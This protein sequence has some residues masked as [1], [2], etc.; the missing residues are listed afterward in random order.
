MAKLTGY[1]VA[2]V[3]L[4]A[5]GISFFSSQLKIPFNPSFLIIGGIIIVVIGIILAI[6][7]TEK[8][9]EEVPIYEGKGKERKVVGYQRMKK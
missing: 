4:I 1:I 9:L 6:G 5:I 2:L 7:K 3:G 8:Q